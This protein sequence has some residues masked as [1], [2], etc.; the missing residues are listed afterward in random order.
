[1]VELIS[2]FWGHRGRWGNLRK[3]LRAKRTTFTEKWNE[4]S[5]PPAGVASRSG[6]TGVETGL[7]AIEYLYFLY[8]TYLVKLSY[9]NWLVVIHKKSRNSDNPSSFIK[10]PTRARKLSICLI[11]FDNQRVSFRIKLETRDYNHNGT[12]GQCDNG[13]RGQYHNGTR[14]YQ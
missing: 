5:E 4:R 1:M 14:D 7:R 10:Y 9:Q 8:V 6:A 2:S 11:R 12:G 13:T 3:G